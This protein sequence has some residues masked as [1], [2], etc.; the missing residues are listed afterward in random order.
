MYVLSANMCSYCGRL[1][2]LAGGTTKINGGRERCLGV[3]YT[4][5][6][7]TATVEGLAQLLS[8]HHPVADRALAQPISFLYVT[9][10]QGG[11]GVTRKQVA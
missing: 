1:G 6:S 7:I 4:G 9:L 2:G 3:G 8:S 11:N 5:H 10:Q